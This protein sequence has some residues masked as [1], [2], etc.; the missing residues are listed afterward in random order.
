MPIIIRLA[1]RSRRGCELNSA[2]G[3]ERAGRFRGYQRRPGAPVEAGSGGPVA[4]DLLLSID[5]GQIV[6]HRRL[7][8]IRGRQVGPYFDVARSA[9]QCTATAGQGG[10][11]CPRCVG[12]GRIRDNGGRFTVEIRRVGGSFRKTSA[13]DNSPS[14]S[15]GFYN[16]QWTFRGGRTARETCLPCG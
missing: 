16:F 7:L 10:Q 3:P 9:G 11:R 6:D 13:G 5:D 2:R 15:A 14:I 1:G 4:S 12:H 8:S